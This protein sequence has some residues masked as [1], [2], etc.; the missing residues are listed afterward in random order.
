MQ[1]ILDMLADH[2]G[3]A[4]TLIAGGPQ[5]ADGGRLHMT[6]YVSLTLDMLH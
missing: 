3:W 2:S 1:P 4:V 5:P 6:R